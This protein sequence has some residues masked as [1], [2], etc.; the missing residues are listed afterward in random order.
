MRARAV[1]GVV[2]V[3]LAAWAL[4]AVFRGERASA[5]AA[6]RSFTSS[7]Q[8]REC[9]ATV[10]AEWEV[11]QHAQAWTNP[12]V[13]ALSNDFANT[14]CIDCHAPR[15]VFE[16]GIGERVLPRS[17][18]RS[19]GVDCIACHLLPDGRVAGGV[20]NPD[21][22]C[23]PVATV[24]L[25]RPE[26]CAGCHDQHETVKQWRASSAFAR[27]DD[28]IACH[29]PRRADGSGRTHGMWGGHDLELVASAVRIAARRTDAGVVVDVENAFDGHSFPTDERS[30]AA[31]LFWRPKA[32][33]G[34]EP[35]AW[36]HAYRFRS[37]YRH[38]VDIPD[39]LLKA[40]ETRA[41]TI[42]DPDTAGAIEVALFYKRKPYWEDA[43][44]P[45][46]EREAYLLH[47]LELEAA[48]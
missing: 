45:D 42:V 48:R 25:T 28:C 36:R 46:P 19:E 6:A 20:D 30:R 3:A 33:D 31:D 17:S 14:D 12:E 18:R 24:D 4:V 27:G 43:E 38:E 21:A 37:P 9:H 39:T 13:R 41:V 35:G 15:P 10:F 7:Q 44:R 47:A 22:A 2:L 11:S 5:P 40:D 32:R 8:C 34:A 23:R 16:T 29:M 26:F 1:L